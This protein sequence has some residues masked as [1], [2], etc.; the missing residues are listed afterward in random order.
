MQ[1]KRPLLTIAIPTYN[2]ARFLEELLNC[3]QPQL[4]LQPSIELIVSDNASTDETQQLAEKF[5][6]NGLLF[7]YIRNA[8]NIGP[9]KNFLQCLNLAAGKYVWLLGDDD[10]LTPDALAQL[11]SLLQQ[12]E[13]TRDFDLV[14]L[15]SF[16]FTGKYELPPASL[17]KDRLGRFAEVVTDGAYFLEKVNGLIGLISVV[18]IN[19]DRLVQQSRFA[20]DRLISTYL[21]QVGWSFPVLHAQC[22]VLYIWERLLAYRSFNSGGWG[23]AELFGLRLGGI[24]SEY[25]D[26]E[27]QL[28]NALVNGVLRYWLPST[29]MTIRLENLPTMKSENFAQILQP[30]FSSNWRYWV[31][32]YPIA[33]FPLRLSRMI[34]R[35][36]F[37]FNKYTRAF[38]AMYR[39]LFIRDEQL[40]PSRRLLPQPDPSRDERQ[41]PVAG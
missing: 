33:V 20:L 1:P 32:I 22:R 26:E 12:G 9:D 15:S 23:A 39:Y 30:A 35:C 25:F 17:R 6:R 27:P 13:E 5:A 28:A 4:S 16:G 36:L 21:P 24:A 11:I 18:V 29:I 37:T 38:Q 31:F 19:K 7:R 14:Y 34:H 8:E 40:W 2:R 3:L 41:T 10:L